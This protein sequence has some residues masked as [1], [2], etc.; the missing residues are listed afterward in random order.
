MKMELFIISLATPTAS[1][2]RPLDT[3]VTRLHVPSAPASFVPRVN[4]ALSGESGGP[5][6]LRMIPDEIIFR[7]GLGLPEK[8]QNRMAD[9]CAFLKLTERPINAIW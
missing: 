1:T 6:Y 9:V 7:V 3:D 5:G 8:E 2:T 4:A